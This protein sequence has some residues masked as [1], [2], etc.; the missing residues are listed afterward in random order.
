MFFL[1]LLI[2]SYT[3][4]PKK[5]FLCDFFNYIIYCRFNFGIPTNQSNPQDAV[6]AGAELCGGNLVAES[7][8]AS[9]G[10]LID[11][12]ETGAVFDRNVG[13]LMVRAHH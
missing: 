13:E 11:G 5:S 1:F 6:P 3:D 10:A 4:L 9:I 7:I 8:S 12:D 2:S